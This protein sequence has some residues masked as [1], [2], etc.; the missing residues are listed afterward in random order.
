MTRSGFPSFGVAVDGGKLADLENYNI[1]MVVMKV[2]AARNDSDLAAKG[3]QTVRLRSLNGAAIDELH[4]AFVRVD[5]DPR[6][7][8]YRFYAFISSLVPKST[9]LI[10][11]EVAGASKDRRFDAAVLVDRMCVMVAASKTASQATARD[12]RRF[13]ESV[14]DVLDGEQGEG[15][16]DAVFASGAGAS[17]GAVDAMRPPIPGVVLKLAVF[18]D[19]AWGV[20]RFGDYPVG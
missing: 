13:R 16:V 20:S 5:P 8:T 19:G 7:A 12:I 2:V 9:M 15:L 11:H 3:R 10:N 14:Q 4:R 6:F 1:P 17:S 18:E